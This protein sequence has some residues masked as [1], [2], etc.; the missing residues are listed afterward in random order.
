MSVHPADMI[1]SSST[2]TAAALPVDHD[3]QAHAGDEASRANADKAVA[4]AKPVT[5][6]TN[7]SSRIQLVAK[8]A[9]LLEGSDQ[10]KDRANAAKQHGHAGSTDKPD[11]TEEHT[12]QKLKH[13]D[14]KVRAHERAHSAAGGSFA[15]SPTYTFAEGSGGRRYAVSGEVQI[16]AAPVRDNPK[17][18]IRKMEIVISAALAPADPSSQDLAVARQAQTTR[19]QALATINKEQ[20]AKSENTDKKSVDPRDDVTF[21][22]GQ[23]ILQRDAQAA[24]TGNRVSDNGTIA[25]EIF[26]A[27]LA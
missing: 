23:T 16:D 17:E 10:P 2:H 20:D 7:I 8:L 18:T 13:V 27:L 14:A 11:E 26:S 15:G 22:D 21:E 4:D 25:T 24:Y 19:A 1:S 9:A 12:E 3:F 5:S 6:H